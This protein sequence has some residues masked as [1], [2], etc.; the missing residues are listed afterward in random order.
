MI[1]SDTDGDVFDTQKVWISIS[2]SM[3]HNI[4]RT[5]SG[6]NFI[7]T[8]S[9]DNIR[10]GPSSQDQIVTKTYAGESFKVEGMVGKWVVIIHN[11]EVAYTHNSNGY[12]Q[13]V[14]APPAS[15][16]P[17]EWTYNF[18]LCSV[19]YSF[20]H[21]YFKKGYLITGPSIR[22]QNLRV[23]YGAWDKLRTYGYNLG[24][25][26]PTYVEPS[27]DGSGGL[28]FDYYS[29]KKGKFIDYGLK[30]EA[31]GSDIKIGYR[32]YYKDKFA[33]KIL[34]DLSGLHL[35]ISVAISFHF[36]D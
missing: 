12:I 15:T 18:S 16:T 26:Y 29:S 20:G 4:D 7:I 5:Y 14:K 6:R 33:D 3:H 9:V 19:G 31:I 27:G 32:Q 25:Y 2:K 22:M 34:T 10:D 24:L 30:G 21:V 36:S 11:G 17:L 8:K 23:G 35:S 28:Y 13:G 1:Q